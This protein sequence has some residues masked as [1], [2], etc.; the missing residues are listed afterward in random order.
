[1]GTCE[2]KMAQ[3][4]EGDAETFSREGKSD[5]SSLSE[6][7]YNIRVSGFKYP[8]I[9]IGLWRKSYKTTSQ[10]SSCKSFPTFWPNLGC[11]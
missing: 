4:K 1:M 2:T 3:M 11:Q 7:Q 10:R 8:N 5:Q 9:S 6:E